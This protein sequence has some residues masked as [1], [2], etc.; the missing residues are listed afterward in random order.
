MHTLNAVDHVAGLLIGLAA[1]YMDNDRQQD[2]EAVENLIG[3]ASTLVKTQIR[4][5]EALETIASS[6][7][8]IARRYVH[9]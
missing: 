9:R 6:L 1:R 7:S 5:T 4:Q 2:K 8:D 3:L